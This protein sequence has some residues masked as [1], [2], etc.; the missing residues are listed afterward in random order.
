MDR[1]LN[2]RKIE[3][4]VVD[5]RL[6]VGVGEDPLGDE[7]ERRRG[8]VQGDL[9]RSRADPVVEPGEARQVAGAA[10]H[11]V[12][13]NRGDVLEGQAGEE[14][15]QQTVPLLLQRQLLIDVDGLGP[16]EQVPGLELD[17]GGGDDQELR[18]E[19]EVEGAHPLEMVE[20]L[21]DQHAQAELGDVDLV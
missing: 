15:G 11:A 9:G 4:E 13:E 19:F 2:R 16:G 21:G 14:A 20:V 17:E 5:I 7:G 3:L 1:L 8:G 6:V 18:G 10:L 12:G